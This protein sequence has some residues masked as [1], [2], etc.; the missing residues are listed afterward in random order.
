MRV[1]NIAAII[2]EICGTEAAVGGPVQ[3]V[4]FLGRSQA[5]VYRVVAAGRNFIVHA[6]PDGTEYL[7]RLRANLDTVAVL[8]DSRIP[9]E[10]AWRKSNGAWAV[11]MYPEIPGEELNASNATDW[12]LDSLGDLLLGL[13]TVEDPAQPRNGLAGRV[14]EPSAFA[15]FGEMLIHR[16]SDL[17]IQTDR[18]RRHLDVMSAYLGEHASEFRIQTRL[19]HGDLHRSNIVST[20]NSVGLLDWGDLTAGDYAFDLATMKFVLDAVAP[21]EST[22]FI[23]ARARDYRERFHDGTL[24]IRMRFFLALAGLVRAFNCADDRSAFGPGRAWRVR[25]C[26]L[27][28]ESQWRRPLKLDGGEAGAPSVRTED[29]ALDMRQPMRGLFYLVAPRRVS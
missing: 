9:R 17:P 15:A 5:D 12:V 16:L 20:G 19:I 11:L 29:W 24:E 14:N 28:S 25:T 26:Y 4:D 8:D 13:H 22:A 21:R 7:K 23:R 1:L 18:V 10:V 3:R 27:H 2:D 6:T